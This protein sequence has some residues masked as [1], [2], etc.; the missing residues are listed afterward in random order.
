MNIPLNI[1]QDKKILSLEEYKYH[2]SL[3]KLLFQKRK[4]IE[5]IKSKKITSNYTQTKILKWFSNLNIQNRI[6]VCSIYNSWLI[7]IIFQMIVYARFDSVVEFYPTQNY[8][9]FSKNIKFRGFEE[10]YA[11]TYI[12]NRFNE[13]TNFD[14]FFTFFSGENNAKK[15]TG[16]P[17][18]EDLRSINIK[19]HRENEFIKEIRFLSLSEFNDTLT[20]GI[21]LLNKPEKMMEYFNYFSSSQSFTEAII[22]YQEINKNYNFSF[23][24]WIANYKCFSIHQ[25]I[26]IFLEQIIS[27]YYQ[28]FLI[29][30][31][32]PQFDIDKKFFDFFQSNSNIEEYLT[33]KNLYEENENFDFIDKE[34][35]YNII[36]SE[37]Q[38]KMIQYFEN[39][40]ELVYSYA[41][42]SRYDGTNNNN[43]NL[44]QQG[45]INNKIRELIGIYK[46]NIHLFVLKISFIESSEAFLYQNF[47]C[48]ILYQQLI[49]QYSNQYYNELLI[50]EEQKINNKNIKSK[51]NKK[52]KNKKKQINTKEETNNKNIIS[53]IDIDIN[54]DENITNIDEEKENN[55]NDKNNNNNEEEEEIEEI[56]SDTIIEPKEDKFENESNNITSYNDINNS[57]VSSSHT[58]KCSKDLNFLGPKY[59]N[60]FRGD[61]KEEERLLKIEMEDLSEEKSEDEKI[62]E[63]ENAKFNIEDIS[64]NDISEETL[65]NEDICISFNNDDE[66]KKK[67]KKNKKRNKNRKKK[68]KEQKENKKSEFNDKDEQNDKIKNIEKNNVK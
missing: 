42:A 55:N 21:D 19:E 34:K 1:L 10:E 54:A 39:K 3:A 51:K 4:Y 32:I 24:K 6:K 25:L 29:E 47:I 36:N 31:E 35:I 53:N 11:E 22:S 23:P 12:K 37:K 17:N 20:L 63:K 27:I 44:K 38:K 28:L 14:E 48:Y 2:Q 15:G 66:N 16:T 26:I 52:R 43:N 58:N 18:S 67:K 41:Y 62:E 7:N 46:K 50:E 33:K 13:K 61:K 57:T 65:I 49:E 9:E 60:F 56:P 68:L 64:E 59:N 40:I 8:E 45:I 5:N 30:N